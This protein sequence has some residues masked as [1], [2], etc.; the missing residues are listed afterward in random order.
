MVFVFILVFF[1]DVSVVD[2]FM[3]YFCFLSLILFVM[4]SKR[5]SVDV[6][7]FNVVV[8]GMRLLLILC[9]CCFM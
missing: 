1:G 5:E 6:E 8:I 3:V 2:C 9:L 4:T 7:D